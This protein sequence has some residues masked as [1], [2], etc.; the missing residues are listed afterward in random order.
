MSLIDLPTL[1]LTQVATR[2]RLA[3]TRALMQ[4]VQAAAEQAWEREVNSGAGLGAAESGEEIG[5]RTEAG[6][7]D[8]GDEGVWG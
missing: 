6:E 4:R 3:D 8:R 1:I 7:N 2:T 5:W